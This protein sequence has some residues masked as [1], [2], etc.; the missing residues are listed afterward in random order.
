MLGSALVLASCGGVRVAEQ[1]LPESLTWPPGDPRIRLERIVQARRDWQALRAWIGGEKEAGVFERPYAVA[2]QGEDLLV[3]DPGA[4]RVVRISPEGRLAASPEGAADAPM[5]I[6][7]CAIG[8]LTVDPSQGRLAVLGRD[9]KRVRWLVEGL[10]RPTG[11]ACAGERTYVVETGAHRVLV[12]EPDGSRKSFGGRGGGEGRFNFPTAVTLHEG[13]LL[14]AD[15]LNFRVQ[16]LDA[17]GGAYLGA[18]GQLGDG[19]GD[20]PRL[21]GIAVDADGHVWVSDAY[22]DRVSLYSRDGALL[23]SLGGPGEEPGRFSFPAGIAA[24]ADG[25]VAVADSLNRRIQVFRLLR[26]AANP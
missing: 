9:L 4:R 1:R 21:K 8:I 3:A 5:A 23:T 22:L 14:V 25:R 10:D 6:A 11:I 2:W 13:M 17:A 16:R 18:F 7:A 19:A 26:R 24:H 15:T 20:M 12:L